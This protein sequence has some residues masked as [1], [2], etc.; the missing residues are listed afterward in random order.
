MPPKP[1][2]IV[3]KISSASKDVGG[4]HNA[5]DAA[6][7]STSM[8]P[9]PNPVPPRG[10]LEEEITA[11]SSCLQ[12]A[13]VKTGQIYGFYT[14]V[15]RLGIQKYAPHPPRS[16]TASLG[17]EVEKYDQLCDA[18]ESH[19][20]RAIAVLQRDLAREEQRLKAEDEA[21]AAAPKPP[22][23][24]TSSTV[25]PSTPPGSPGQTQMDTLPDGTQRPKATAPT[26][27]RRQ[28]AISL[29]SLSRPAFPHKLDLSASALRIHPEEMIP[30][31]LSSPVTLAPRSART[32]LPPE[33]VMAALGDAASRHVDIDLT[34]DSD[35]DLGGPTG[36]GTQQS[37]DPTLG[38]SADRPIELE[39][40]IDVSYLD[41]AGAAGPSGSNQNLSGAEGVLNM[42]N[43]QQV[44]PKEED[45]M[46]IDLL[47]AFQ[48][49]APSAAGDD[50][51]ASFGMASSGNNAPPASGGS[52]V[53][54]E[55]AAALSFL[56]S[57]GTASS[58][59]GEAPGPNQAGTSGQD[60]QFENMLNSG[61]FGENPT[62]TSDTEV[63]MM[64]IFNM[65]V[66]P[67]SNT[68]NPAS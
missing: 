31:G 65:D 55:S 45:N 20:L 1:R 66:N 59:T 13:V 38:S 23:S 42:G 51:L 63:N 4:T 57:F 35:M 41:N 10:I 53:Q 68:D 18:M 2:P 52:N 64:D 39:L 15:K 11:L 25:A 26:P 12:N 62:A 21:A 56:D 28:S 27:A 46:D 37:M 24:P 6:P 43:D 7:A 36:P 9:P 30:S 34:V 16:L 33:L 8:P 67:Q 50:I 58:S 17:R 54:S 49:V 29:S 14:D 40:D 5:K 44:K 48:N 47:Q 60:G 61:F 3:R 19:L 32:S 22:I